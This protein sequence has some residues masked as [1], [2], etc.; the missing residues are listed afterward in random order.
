MSFNLTTEPWI[1]V[2]DARGHSGRASLL[3]VFQQDDAALAERGLQPPLRDLHARPHER[4]ALMRLLICVAQRARLLNQQPAEY[5]RREEVHGG[6]D[7]LA[8]RR[9]FLQLMPPREAGKRKDD[10]QPIPIQKLEFVD[11]EGTTLFDQH[12]L[13]E[14]T[15]TPAEAS[16]VLLT[17]QNFAAG[18]RVDGCAASQSDAM[19]RAG[20][21]IH[22][23]LLGNSLLDSVERNVVDGK[24]VESFAPL[25]WD[26]S[27]RPLWEHEVPTLAALDSETVKRLTTGYLG[28]LVPLTRSLW[29]VENGAQ[30]VTGAYAGEGLEYPLFWKSDDE[31]AGKKKKRVLV[32]FREVSTA[33]TGEGAG[34]IDLVSATQGGGLPKAVWRELHAISVRRISTGRGGPAILDT[35]VADKADCALLWCGAL[36]GGGQGKSA[37]I[38][39]TIESVFRLPTRLIEPQFEKDKRS[40]NNTYR[41]GVAYADEWQKRLAV[42]V[43]AYRRALADELE[44]KRGGKRGNKIKGAAATHFWT[45][46]EQRSQ[47]LLDVACESVLYMDGNKVAWAKTPWGQRVLYAARVAFEHAC[48]RGTPSQMRAYAAGLKVL[49]KEQ[50]DNTTD[51]SKR[52]RKHS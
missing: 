31:D 44:G 36:I 11:A 13:P 12:V 2:V 35:L 1:P 24:Q 19:C 48:P 23:F 38:S 37:K 46:L 39:D 29:L 27:D 41:S 52:T 4:I 15:I 50:P 8:E 14:R 40:V 47:V 9:R 45:A 7:L 5:L 34:D 18:G 6:F 51:K 28:R 20:A 32:G 22:S 42:A 30:Q 17:F 21:A 49:F 16:V 25:S 43:A 10:K 33:V 3:E 26:D